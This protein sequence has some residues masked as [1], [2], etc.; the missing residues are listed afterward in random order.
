MKYEK[1]ANET[2]Q[3]TCYRTPSAIKIDG[4]LTKPVWK[5]AIKSPRFVDMIN[6]SLGYFDTRASVLWDD[7]ALY[8]GFWVEEP[9]VEAK[10]TKR[11]DIIFQEND[12]EIFI[13]GGDCYYEFEIN[14]LNTV[15][16]VFFIWQDA[17]RKFDAKEFDIH[18]REAFTFGGNHDRDAPTFW[19]GNHPRGL[20]WAYTD[21]DFPGLKS[22][23]QVQ[24]S[25][26]D[27]SDID[28]GWTVEIALPWTGMK[29]LA[30]GRSLPP[31]DG[32]VWRIFFGRFG[33]HANGNSV[34]QNAMSWDKIG[35][36]DNHLPERFTPI[37]FSTQ[38]Q[39][40]DLS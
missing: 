7:E 21:W 25:I 1:N 24:G 16:E 13:D 29:Q 20:R 36:N 5:N 27:N 8:V 23:V 31:A 28:K 38:N 40:E 34:I 10:L 32:D 6:G 14:A 12:V 19:R 11:D 18:S 3:Y 26:N 35:D 39:P 33:R 30:N 2:E 17:F 15:Y 9:F 22:A 4:D 37:R